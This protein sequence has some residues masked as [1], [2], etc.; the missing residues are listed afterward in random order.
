MSKERMIDG[1]KFVVTPFQAV[2]AFKLKSYLIRKFG[3]TLG[4]ALGTLKD[5]LPTSGN[6]GDIK[7]DGDAIGRAVQSLAEQLDE[8]EFVTFLKR[9]LRNVVAHVKGKQFAF[10]DDTFDAALDIVFSGKLFSVYPV[11]LLVLEANY[12]DFFGKVA[13]GIGSKIQKI[14]TSGPGEEDLKNESEKSETLAS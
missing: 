12:P 14:I 13:R 1:I 2:E 7:L 3:P 4:Q 9:M 6:I 8:D 11:L 5:G 10:T